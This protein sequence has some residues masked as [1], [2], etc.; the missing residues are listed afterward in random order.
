MG[1]KKSDPRFRSFAERWMVARCG[2]F[3]TDPHG[4]AEDTWTTILDAKRAYAMI[5]RTGLSIEPEDGV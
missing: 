2:L 4:L 3:R 5:K 1:E